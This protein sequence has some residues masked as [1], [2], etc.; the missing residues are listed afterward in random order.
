MIKCSVHKPEK[1]IPYKLVYKHI[2][3]VYPMAYTPEHANVCLLGVYS[4]GSCHST[5]RKFW[6]LTVYYFSNSLFGFLFWLL[7]DHM[8]ACAKKAYARLPI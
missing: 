2:Y 5:I 1:R 7:R 4:S 6:A 8:A 3:Y